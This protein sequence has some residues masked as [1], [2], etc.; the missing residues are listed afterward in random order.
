MHAT[1]LSELEGKN[2]ITASP[3]YFNTYPPWL[4]ITEATSWENARIMVTS[5][6]TG[7]IMLVFVEPTKPTYII[8]SRTL[9]LA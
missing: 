9:E 7:K 8:M 2:A 6:S 4:C 1:I 3:P 5:L